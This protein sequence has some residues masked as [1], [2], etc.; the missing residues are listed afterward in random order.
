MPAKGT[1]FPI[2]FPEVTGCLPAGKPELGAFVYRPGVTVGLGGLHLEGC[3]KHPLPSLFQATLGYTK[4]GLKK[5]NQ[6]EMVQQVKL[7]AYW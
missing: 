5:Q 7:A 2:S 3:K 1:G 4:P 6:G